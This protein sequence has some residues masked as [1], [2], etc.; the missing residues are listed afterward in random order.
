MDYGYSIAIYLAET[1]EYVLVRNKDKKTVTLI[2]PL[3][4]FA[5]EK[6]N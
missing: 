6:E 4:S 1:R 2:L 3:P 5:E